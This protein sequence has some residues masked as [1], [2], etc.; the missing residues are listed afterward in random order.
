MK[1]RP[2]PAREKVQ[3][4]M[5]KAQAAT[6][7][8]LIGGLIILIILP[9]IYVFYSYSHQSN[10][11]MKQSQLN[12]VGTDIVDL[13]EK[14]Y[15]LGEPSKVTLDATIP[16]G[17]VGMEIWGDHENKELVFFLNDGTQIPFKSNVNITS[18]NL[19]TG[20]RCYYNFSEEFY[21]SGL[22]HLI[23]KSEG[24]NVLITMLGEA[25]LGSPPGADSFSHK[26]CLNGRCVSLEGGGLDLCIDDDWCLLITN[27][28][29]EYIPMYFGGV[30]QSSPLYATAID[31]NIG[32]GTTTPD[33]KLDVN[34]SMNISS[35]LTVDNQANFQKLYFSSMTA[36][37]NLNMNG[38]T[39]TGLPDPD[40]D[41][42]IA[43]KAYADLIL[44][45]G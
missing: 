6:E 9:A 28:E 27:L 18:N 8:L 29:G 41:S 45:G 37:G 1:K 25:P 14:I 33:S 7:Y 26:G 38:N 43:T 21:S 36:G 35:V 34:G 40:E 12:K 19:C 5:E 30:F 15:Y 44:K 2:K 22:K 16:E 13:A 23:I 4:P 20:E 42:D 11:E 3:P 32:V 10:L 39:I 24:N 31:G 17:V